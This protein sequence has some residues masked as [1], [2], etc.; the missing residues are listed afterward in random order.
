MEAQMLIQKILAKK[1]NDVVTVNSTDSI[2]TMLE[3][4]AKENIGAVVVLN[5]GQPIGVLSE[6]DIVRGLVTY[7]VTVI[8]GPC[9]NMMTTLKATC[10]PGSS[11]ETVLE[12]MTEKRV[13]HVPVIDETGLCGIVSI[14]DL[15]HTQLAETE[16]E[17]KQ[18]L[19]YVTS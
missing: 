17:R 14:G 6:R 10:S 4:V 1:G 8:D 9:S 13:R 15:V 2:A 7:G 18:L 5:N 12:T 19:N 3:L 16:Y 11:I